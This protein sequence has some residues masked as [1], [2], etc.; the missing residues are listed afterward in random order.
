MSEPHKKEFH[1]YY[2]IM[3]PIDF[4]VNIVIIPRGWS[5][6]RTIFVLEFANL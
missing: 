5:N 4:P 2:G 3:Q 1:K 6:T